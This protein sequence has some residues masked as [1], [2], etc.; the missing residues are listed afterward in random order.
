MSANPIFDCGKFKALITRQVPGAN[1]AVVAQRIMRGAHVVGLDKHGNVSPIKT[2]NAISN[3]AKHDPYA[4]TVLAAKWDSGWMPYLECPQG[5]QHTRWM[6]S[7]LQGKAKCTIAA[8]G[9]AVG[10]G[11]NYDFHPCK[12]M[13]EVERVRKEAQAAAEL[14]Q[15]QDKT[16]QQRILDASE[17]QNS[18]LVKTLEKLAD[19]VAPSPSGGTKK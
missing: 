9:H 19:A 18:L 1:G 12:C 4:M 16:I 2:H 7:H 10:L 5:T 3:R 11:R 17:Q 15:S 13:V 14:R 8:D 6:P